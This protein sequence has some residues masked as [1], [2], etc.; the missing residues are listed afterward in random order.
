VKKGLNIA[1]SVPKST[2]KVQEIQPD[3]Q[4]LFKIV[5]SSYVFA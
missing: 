4:T 1:A 3:E 2:G 5:L